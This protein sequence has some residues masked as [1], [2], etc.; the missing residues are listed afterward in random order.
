MSSGSSR[1]LKGSVSCCDALAPMSHHRPHRVITAGDTG[2][3]SLAVH[4]QLRGARSFSYYMLFG[5][6]R[7]KQPKH[8]DRKWNSG[9]SARYFGHASSPK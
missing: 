6:L 3:G 2:L 1:S 4:D 7:L 5:Y 9:R 8:S